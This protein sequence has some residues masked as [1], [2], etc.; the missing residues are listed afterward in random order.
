MF[1][2]MIMFFSLIC[3]QY[4][5]SMQTCNEFC[6]RKEK[7]TH[8]LCSHGSMFHNRQSLLLHDLK[9]TNQMMSYHTKFGFEKK[10]VH[11]TWMSIRILCWKKEMTFDPP[12]VTLTLNFGAPKV[13]MPISIHKL[14]FQGNIHFTFWV[15]GDTN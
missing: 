12:S 9:K 7:Y 4:Q 6:P 3:I 1:Q 8:I 10:S 11:W 13:H 2:K 14:E 15:S 5:T